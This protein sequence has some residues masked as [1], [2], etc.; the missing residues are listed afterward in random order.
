[1]LI[2][3]SKLVNFNLFTN[4][5]NKWWLIGFIKKTS[6]I[7]FIFESLVLISNK[8]ISLDLTGCNIEQEI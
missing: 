3:K 5:Q 6:V 8:M 7:V 2:I 1:M 4:R